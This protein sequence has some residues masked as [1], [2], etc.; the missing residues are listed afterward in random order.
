MK[1]LRFAIFYIL[2]ICASAYWVPA[3]YPDV[4]PVFIV[5]IAIGFAVLVGI[6]ELIEIF[7]SIHK[8]I[9]ENK[10]SEKKDA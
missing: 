2:L 4:N 10:P 7:D 3:K 6:T 1:A 8:A 5:M 9:S